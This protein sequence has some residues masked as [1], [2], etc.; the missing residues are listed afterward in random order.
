MASRIGRNPMPASMLNYIHIIRCLLFLASTLEPGDK[1]LIKRTVRVIPSQQHQLLQ[2]R[3]IQLIQSVNF[4][5]QVHHATVFAF[6]LLP[7]LVFPTSAPASAASATINSKAFLGVIPSCS[8]N[9]ITRA[10]VRGLRLNQSI[11]G[12]AIFF[13][14]FL[15]SFF[16][17]MSTNNVDEKTTHQEFYLVE[18]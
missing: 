18:C 4:V 9:S 7:T 14:H 12:R 3:L 2:H 13:I 1:N 16:I 11:S 10:I 5:Y 6:S 15:C 17:N 8:L